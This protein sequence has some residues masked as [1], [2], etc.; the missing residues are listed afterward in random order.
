MDKIIIIVICAIVVIIGIAALYYADK[1]GNMGK[2]LEYITSSEFKRLAAEYCTQAEFL[3]TGNK[4]GTERLAWVCGQIIS[5]IPAPYNALIT[6]AELASLIT[7]VFEGIAS[8]QA[9]GSKKI[10][11]PLS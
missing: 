5:K 7:M 8:K 4:K 11:V 6:A 9:D 1:A 3:I 10:D 2:L